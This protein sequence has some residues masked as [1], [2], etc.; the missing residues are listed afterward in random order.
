VAG[1]ARVSRVD[2]ESRRTG[3]IVRGGWTKADLWRTTLLGG[4]P[5]VIKDFGSKRWP[6][7]LWGRIQIARE[8]R[9]LEALAD[10]GVA[11]RLLDRVDALALA[12]ESL[13]GSS[14]Y[15]HPAGPAARPHLAALRHA[16]ARVHACGI[17][18]ND[19]RGRENVLL[20]EPGPRI[21][22]LD[23]AGAVQLR[24]GGWLFRLWKKVDDS[25]LLKWTEMLD[26]ESLS[27]EDREFLRRF[28]RW[29]RLWPFN[30]KGLGWTRMES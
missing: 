5:A 8:A 24:P 10:L 26:P 2:L 22:V 6:V 27:A 21:V 23:W 9:S 25:A 1:E 7:R 20:V 28:R 29:R 12:V 30:R 19:L 15:L 3:Y 11:P 4:Q 18:H 16:M 14:L 13:E 17:V